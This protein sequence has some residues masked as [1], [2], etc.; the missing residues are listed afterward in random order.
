MAK[1]RD[2]ISEAVTQVRAMKKAA[3]ESAR[4]A[5]EQ[6]MK[7]DLRK[8]GNQTTKKL[9]EEFDADEGDSASYDVAGEQER[10]G[11]EVDAVGGTSTDELPDEGD[12]PAIVEGSVEDEEDMEIEE[13]EEVEVDDE[14]TE[15]E[16]ISIDEPSDDDE[17]IEVIDDE[18]ADDELE[19][20]DDLGDLEDDEV[21]EDED[22]FSSNDAS[23]LDNDAEVVE[24]VD[25]ETSPEAEELK[26]EN[27][28]LVRKMRIL[29]RENVR[30]GKALNFLKSKINEVNLFNARL[31][32]YTSLSNKV[33]LTKKE[34]ASA[35]RRFDEARSVGEVK[36][37]FR[38]LTEA[39]N[40][41]GRTTT[42]TKRVRRPNIQSVV[43]ES[44]NYEDSFTRLN[45]L[46]GLR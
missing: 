11:E 45:E 1:N 19:E 14:V 34:K 4:A 29:Q 15:D 3:M 12:G 16:E 38:S 43:S 44:K 23:G 24:I 31:A 9:N 42:S 7:E 20:D 28:R 21:T 36:R 32:A 17:V 40:A 27:R 46:A 13:D 5:L 41:K 25:D 22:V 8:I 6:S 39:Y 18:E 33:P 37:L 26:T 30:Y 2:L 10:K 35:I